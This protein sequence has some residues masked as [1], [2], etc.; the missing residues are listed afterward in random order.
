MD[1]RGQGRRSR[2]SATPRPAGSSTRSWPSSSSARSTST[3]WS[4]GS[5][6][7]PPSST[8]STG[9]CAGPGPRSRSWCP[10]WPPC[11]RRPTRGRAR[12]E[13]GADEEIGTRGGRP[14]ARRPSRGP[15]TQPGLVLM[16]R[17]AE[18][19]PGPRRGPP[20]LPP[21]ALGPGLRPRRPGGPPDGQLRLRGRRP[22]D[23]RGAPRRPGLRG[24]RPARRAG[25][26]RDALRRRAR[27][28]LPPRPR[29][30]V[31]RPAG[32]SRA[33]PRCSSVVDV[34]VHV[35]RDE[36]P[37]VERATGRGRRPPGRPRQRR[38][39]RRW[40]RSRSSWCTRRAT[41]RA[42]SASWSTGGWSPA[43]PSSSRA[44][45]GPT[46]PAATRR[47]CTSRSPPAWPASPT[48]PSCSRATCTRPTPR[49]RWA[50]RGGELRL[51]PALGRAV[52]GR[53]SAGERRRRSAGG[54]L[55][56]D[57]RWSV[58]GAS[59]GRAAGRQGLRAGGFGGRLVLV[60]AELH[61]PY[62]RPPLSKQ[63][64]AGTWPPEQ[65]VL[66]DR[67][68]AA[69]SSGSSCGSAT[70]RC[71]S[72]PRRGGSS[73][74]TAPSL[75]ADGV[76]VATGARPRR[77]PGTEGIRTV[78]RAAHPRGLRRRSA[79]GIAAARAGR[80]VVV[81]GAGFI[82]SEVAATCAGLGCRVTVVETL[83]T[84]LVA[85]AGRARSGRPAARCTPQRGGAADRRRRRAVHPWDRA[86]RE[87]AG[88]VELTDGSSVPADVV[89]VGHRRRA[90]RSMAGGLGAHSRQRGGLRRRR[91][92]RPTAWWRPATWPAGSGATT[93]RGAGP[94]RALADGRRRWAAPLR[95]ACSPGGADAPAFD[96]V[97]YFWSDQYGVRIQMLGRP[98]P[99]DEVAVVDGSLE[100][101][102]FVALY[103]RKDRLAAALA[104]SRPRQLMAYR[105]LLAA[106]TSWSA[107]LAHAA[108]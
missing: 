11:A 102:R 59:L 66:A 89:V 16:G 101:E 67:H 94:H 87:P 34:P 13:R 88:G 99:N 80:R 60:G 27:H 31:D 106:G 44:A 97:P 4:A 15:T 41:R 82:G 40:A 28:P 23:R 45:A 64:L 33:S 9:G 7:R 52:A 51:P 81:V 61:L 26:R 53:C 50:R 79:T 69:T 63:V 42:A 73:S 103:G 18:T 1:A 48:T 3:S 68:Q 12:D 43:T 100:E 55:A 84:P 37:W 19:S 30:R 5:S 91:C 62:D 65:A 17:L 78:P 72:T 108:R 47:P 105:A 77:L 10:G 107:A 21:A 75:E 32:R 49:R 56:P 104:I 96:P 71:R 35:Q 86:S 20:L 24:R 74:T 8:S 76:V 90:R 22:G 83:P 98:D 57:G 85:G 25:R 54:P 92:S 58:V 46:C 36:V 2:S 93:A 29:R 39:G 14:P 95:A 70:G 38:R 6:G